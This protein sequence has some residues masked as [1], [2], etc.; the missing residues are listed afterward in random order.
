MRGS[1]EFTGGFAGVA[2]ELGGGLLVFPGAEESEHAL[3]TG[4][5]DELGG[6]EPVVEVIADGE[7]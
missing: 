6:E 4:I 2:G 7:E 1:V 5:V 3:E